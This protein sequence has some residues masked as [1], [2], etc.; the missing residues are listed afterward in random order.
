MITP[1]LSNAKFLTDNVLKASL[2]HDFGKIVSYCSKRGLEL[3]YYIT[4]IDLIEINSYVKN[5]YSLRSFDKNYLV[6]TQLPFL[7]IQQL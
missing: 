2:Y 4:E 1:F 3:K 5:K 7:N 6:P